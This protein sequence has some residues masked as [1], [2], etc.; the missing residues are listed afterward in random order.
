VWEAGYHKFNG[1][2][3]WLSDA[4]KKILHLL[5]FRDGF[6]IP[7]EVRVGLS[8]DLFIKVK[9]E[10]LCPFIFCSFDR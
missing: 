10:V 5:G 9:V 2:K 7:F 4:I 8:V 3:G 1:L 6:A